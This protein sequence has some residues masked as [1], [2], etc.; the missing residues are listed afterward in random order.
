[1]GNQ[2]LRGEELTF[3]KISRNIRNRLCGDFHRAFHIL[4]VFGDKVLPVAHRRNFVVGV[5]KVELAVSGFRRFKF[6]EDGEDFP[7]DYS[8]WL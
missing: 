7:W 1:M 4:A 2:R 8:L 6:I 5:G 3:V